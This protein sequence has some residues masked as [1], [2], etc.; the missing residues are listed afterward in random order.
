MARYRQ[1]VCL[2]EGL[3]LDLNW[4]IRKNILHRNTITTARQLR[5]SYTYTEETIAVGIVSA[6]LSCSAGGWLRIAVGGR[7]QVLSLQKDPR[8]YGGGQWYFACPRTGRRASVLWRPPGASYFASRHSWPSQVAYSSQFQGRCDRALTRGQ[9]LRCRLGGPD[10]AG[11]TGDD[12]PKPKWMRWATYHRILDRSNWYE[13][14][15]DEKLYSLVA[16]WLS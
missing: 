15:A 11:Y 9:G 7:E 1:R 16:R 6:D 2:Q 8:P 5:W 10:W 14:I 3:R 12:P 4:L 13:G